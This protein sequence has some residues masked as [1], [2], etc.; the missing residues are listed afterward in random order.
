MN[1]QN[2]ILVSG[3]TGQQ[4]GSVTKH[5][6]RDGWRVRALVRDPE[7]ENAQALAEQG[8]EL[9]QG[10]L[11]D[12]ASLDSA[13][14]GAYGA[15][16]VQNYWLPDVGFDGEVKQG[17]L[18]A[19]AAKAAGVRHFVYTSVGAAHRGM[20]QKHFDS[21]WIIEQYLE[22]IG[23]PHSI[24]RPAAFMNNMEWNRAAIS[25]GTFT[26][27]GIR[28][29]KQTQLI[30]VDDIGAIVA[31]VFADRQAYLGKTIEIAGDELTEME[32]AQTLSRVI[33]RPV[34]LVQPEMPAD[35]TPDPEQLAGANFFNGTA[36]TA[37]IASIRVLYP[38]LHTYEAYLRANGWEDLPVLPMPETASA[39]GD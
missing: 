7:K 31:I 28:P 3:A 4:G 15:F 32:Q 8:V 11:N 35:N 36:Y 33:G 29:D 9:A 14:K 13:L 19:D 27:W 16:S 34:E 12:R 22:E 2:I 18:L 24:V 6:L 17:K 38:G 39:W 26:S 10:D 25:N 20:G 5:L 1:E 37:D 30:A 23:I 21:K